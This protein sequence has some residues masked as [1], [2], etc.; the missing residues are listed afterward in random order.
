M[1]GPLLAVLGPPSNCLLRVR[2]SPETL[3]WMPRV[4]LPIETKHLV[5]RPLRLA[6]AVELH[7]LYSDAEAMRF[8]DDHIPTTLAESEEWAQ[9]K[10]DL[11]ER[12]DGL[13]LWAI[14]ERETGSVVGD[15][16]LQWE[17]YD[18]KVLDLGCRLIRRYWGRGYATEASRAVLA[19]GFRD[20]GVERICAAT[21]VGN[22][23][24]H[25][26]LESLG[27][28]RLR[29]VH[30]YG[31]DMTLYQFGNPYPGA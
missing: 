1:S 5:I 6:D 7:E 18:G 4:Q 13:S 2:L 3:R 27:G 20:L 22:V 29:V 8:L 17:T 10:I 25:R 31:M 30:V 11:F 28:E 16:G 23:R 26:V 12:D 21:H 15:G 9:S 19:A 24:A 14:V